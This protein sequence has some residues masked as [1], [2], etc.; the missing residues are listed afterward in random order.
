MERIRQRRDCLSS[1]VLLEQASVSPWIQGVYEKLMTTEQGNDDARFFSSS[2]LERPFQLSKP[3]IRG[4]T[5]RLSSVLIVGAFQANR[6]YYVIFSL[7]DFGQNVGFTTSQ[8]SLAAALMN[9]GQGVGHPIIGLS[10]DRWGRLDVAGISTLLAGLTTL[11]I[12]VFAGKD[13]AGL[14]IYALCGALAGCLWPT[15][16]ALAINIKD[17]AV[18]AT[19]ASNF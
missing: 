3:F 16:I 6:L 14:L 11:F 10:N 4:F 1:V 12:W 15:P 13:F 17:G 5:K 2:F 9:L 18:T 7:A 8:A 19:S